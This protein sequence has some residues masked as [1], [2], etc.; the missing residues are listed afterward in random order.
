MS[1]SLPAHEDLGIIDVATILVAADETAFVASLR[2]LLEGHGFDVLTASDGVAA[3]DLARNF[4]IDLVILDVMLAGLDGF[5]VCQALRTE[6]DAAIIMLTVAEETGK[7][8]C[9]ELQ[10]DAISQR[11]FGLRELPSRVGAILRW[12][13]R[14]VVAPP[15]DHRATLPRTAPIIIGDLT[16]MPQERRVFRHTAAVP[17][18]DHE[19]KVLAFLVA[20]RGRDCS[21]PEMIAGI[22]QAGEHVTPHLIAY[23]I[24]Q[25]R[26]KLEADPSRPVYIHTVSRAGMRGYRFEEP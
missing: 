15:V 20:N 19:F 22:W 24:G 25:L 4:A 14:F 8:V 6:C 10:T 23:F 9:L 18:T 13:D 2:S 17:L 11:P 16:I 26:K 5:K 7:I 1:D 12:R 21:Y 3:L